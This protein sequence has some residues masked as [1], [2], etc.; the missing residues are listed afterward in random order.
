MVATASRLPTSVM[1]IEIAVMDQMKTV[2]GAAVSQGL[3]W[4]INSC[5]AMEPAL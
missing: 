4:L 5:V 2:K 3:V 1:A